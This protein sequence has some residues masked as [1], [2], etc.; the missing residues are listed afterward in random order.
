[1]FSCYP[2]TNKAQMNINKQVSSVVG[3]KPILL[4]PYQQEMIDSLRARF[5]QGKKRLVMVLPTGGGKTAIFTDITR[6]VVERSG[7]VMIVTDRKELHQQGGNSLARIGVGY[8]ELTANTR[9]IERAPVII[10]MVE[11]LK[12]RL[13]RSG[14]AMFVRS[15]DMIIIDE[16]HKQTF[17]R[18]FES[19]EERQLVIGATAT[20]YR[21]GRMRPLNE[22]YDGMVCGPEIIDLIEQGYLCPEKAYGVAV[23]LSA[24]RI[25]AG[26][27]NDKDL[28]KVYANRKLFDGVVE[29]WKVF[30]EGRKTLAF[31]AT[32]DNSR[33]LAEEFAGAGYRAAHLDADTSDRDR[34]RM[35][36]DFEAGMY[37]VLCNCGI[38][39]TGYDCSSIECVILYRA[40][41]SLPL[42]LQMCGR[43]SR[44]Y[45]GKDH[46]I[47]LDFGQN[48]Q[49]HG[50]WR[51]QRQWTLDIVK[52]PKARKS[53]GEMGMA[54]CPEC[55]AL[56][57]ARARKC[58][59]CGW[60]R[61]Q[62][63]SEKIVITLKEMSPSE[64]LRFAGTANIE[65]LEML[66]EARGW[67]V[68]FV[69]HRLKTMEDFKEYEKLKKYKR[70]WA[71]KNGNRYLGI[72]AGWQ[73]WYGPGSERQ[74]ASY[75]G[76]QKRYSEND[77]NP[78]A[79]QMH[80]AR[81]V[82]G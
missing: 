14:Y 34:R 42:Y 20:P 38:L 29:N 47:L 50:F 80:T 51:N 6:R 40:T 81:E 77:E 26:E 32:V 52:P 74:N 9:R 2:T 56:L 58:V 41:M 19:L 36:R 54:T 60:E 22:D 39:T 66:R 53:V 67:K 68:G 30:A 79:W 11:T 61:E 55:K 12:R 65:G 8:R 27:F 49:R 21:T 59:F 13:K 3:T 46:F 1:M 73:E 45:T 76:A 71:M 64:A 17:T 43:G 18:L 63:E 37:D 57:A 75:E 5:A 48:V 33:Q 23:D 16:A 44:P 15:F 82:A 24:V 70:G 78:Y 35:L 72:E 28:G 69:M 4:R 25:T 10:A 7:R 31:C 62:E